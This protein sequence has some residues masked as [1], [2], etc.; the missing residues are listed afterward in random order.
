M[1]SGRDTAHRVAKPRRFEALAWLGGYFYASV[2]EFGHVLAEVLLHRSYRY[3][4]D[5]RAV[6]FP[7]ATQ[8]HKKHPPAAGH[9]LS[10]RQ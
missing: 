10:S 3:V 7:F 9:S 4:K 6:R 5:R 2:A 8:P 1:Y